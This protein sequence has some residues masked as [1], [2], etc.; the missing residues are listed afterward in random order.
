MAAIAVS[1]AEVEECRQAVLSLCTKLEQNLD[2][3]ERLLAPIRAEWTGSASEAFVE[4]YT[5]WRVEA[6]ALHADLTWIH[7]MVC[8]AQTNFAAA[9][10]AVL[11]TWQAD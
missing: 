1:F 7:S 11:S 6:E 5:N 2:D 8:N 4:A 10:T 3:L 9:H